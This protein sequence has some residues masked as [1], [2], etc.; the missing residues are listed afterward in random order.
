MAGHRTVAALALVA[1]GAALNGC[2]DDGNASSKASAAASAAVSK[3]AS[4]ASSLATK[5]ADAL[6]SAS[7]EARRRLDGV[8]DGVQAKDEVRLG[9]PA[10]DTDGRTT[11]EVTADNKADAAKSFAVQVTFKDQ[12]GKLL[13]TVVVT[14]NDVPAGKSG[15]AT[16]R[17][18][19]NLSGQ[20]LADV[21][22]ALRY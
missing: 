11:V 21:T 20:V 4:A 16:A 12:D 19:H 1:A 15:T 18:T 9:T 8:K 7:A 17:S 6:A 2:S 13:D 5:G 22:R 3:A 10:T 14:L